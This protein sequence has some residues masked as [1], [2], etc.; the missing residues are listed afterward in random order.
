MPPYEIERNFFGNLYQLN[1]RFTFVDELKIID[2]SE[3]STP[4]VLV[5]FRQGNVYSAAYHGKIPEWFE[6]NLPR[7]YEKIIERE[8][9][10]ENVL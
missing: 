10:L 9:P 5:I 7:L 8:P 6:Q 2:T 4:K 1:R 3:S